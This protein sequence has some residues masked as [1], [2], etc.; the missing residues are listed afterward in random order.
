MSETFLGHPRGLLICGL[1][2]MWEFFSYFGMR[3]ILI[4]Y[5][6][7]GLG[8][9]EA[10]GYA[11]YGAF[12][13]LTWALPIVGGTIAD[14][15]LGRHRAIIAGAGAMAAG[16]ALLALNEARPGHT[17]PSGAL[18]PTD[19]KFYGLSL[20]L[21]I[22]LVGAGLLKG[23]ITSLVGTLYEE[24]DAR[25]DAGYTLFYFAAN[26]GGAA[27]PLLCGWLGQHWG[28]SWGFGASSVG[29][30]IGLMV[31]IAG[32]KYLPR[33]EQRQAAVQPGGSVFRINLLMVFGTLVAGIGLGSLVAR[34]DLLGA[35]LTIFAIGAVGLLA[36]WTIARCSPAERRNMI[37]IVGVSSIAIVFFAF[38]EQ[39]G[40]SLNLFMDR[41]VDLSVGAYHPQASQMISLAALFALILAP[42]FGALWMR[43][44]RVGRNPRDVVK[45]SMGLGFL[46]LAFGVPVLGAHLSIG[47]M[48]IVW[49]VVMFFFME[50][51]EVCMVPI[52]FSLVSSLS[53]L[54]F[55]GAMMGSYFLCVALGSF[56]S[57]QLAA[58]T[59]SKEVGGLVTESS[60]IGAYFSFSLALFGAAF[61]V[62]IGLR[63][64]RAAA[65]TG[66]RAVA[67]K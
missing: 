24:S 13:G 3:A 55:A 16:Y 47:R 67:A 34:N 45:L 65:W 25:R 28:W 6:T 36:F 8:L 58:S 39:M 10:D 37:A 53:P 52:T 38:Y 46:G 54:R 21:G 56:L 51:A 33:S 59:A 19:I 26:I 5:L 48:S 11:L 63:V 66:N 32:D 41:F 43:L 20:S 27:A 2:E 23:N 29:M 60:V 7:Q 35:G 64:A 15:F 40:S 42:L 31:F 18:S 22:V 50:C 1:T 61:A 30:L 12:I 62:L 17:L 4:F 14:Q 44:A 49:P 57:G 9:A